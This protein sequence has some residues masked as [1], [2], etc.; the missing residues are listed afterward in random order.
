MDNINNPTRTEEFKTTQNEVNTRT[1]NKRLTS[2]KRNINNAK[3][4]N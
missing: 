4:N 1:S 2:K 3:K